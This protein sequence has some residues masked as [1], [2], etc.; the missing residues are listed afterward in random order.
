MHTIVNKLTGEVK[1]YTDAEFIQERDR[2]LMIWQDAQVK[3]AAA[4]EIEMEA[5]KIAVDFCFDQNKEKGTENI[6]LGNGYKAKAVKKLN[7]G[8]IKTEEG[9][10]NKFAIEKALQKIEKDGEAG[11]LIAE[12]LVKW[13]PDLSMTEYNLLTEK[14]KK[15]IDEVI[16]VT[17]GSPTLEIVP[18]KAP[19]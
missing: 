5:R 3:L 10:V 19:K 14:H 16:V 1:E 15:I 2:L 4:K 6:E 13:T 7:F 12:R 8:F 9:K 18:P 17:P 11:E